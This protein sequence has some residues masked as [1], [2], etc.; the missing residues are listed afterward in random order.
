MRNSNKENRLVK[1]EENYGPLNATLSL[2][3]APRWISD[4]FKKADKN[5]DGRMNFKEVQDLLKMMNVDMNEHHAHRL[6]TVRALVLNAR[7]MATL[8]I[9]ALNRLCSSG[10]PPETTWWTVLGL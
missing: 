7:T 6:F 9:Q 5:N 8:P 10:H 3:G 4:W 1:C 2:S